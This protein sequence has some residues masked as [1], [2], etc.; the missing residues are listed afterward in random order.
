[1]NFEEDNTERRMSPEEDDSEGA[2]EHVHVSLNFD[3]I[4]DKKPRREGE[5]IEKSEDGEKFIIKLA[6]DRV[7]EV[8]AVAYYIWAMCDGDKTV[9]DIIQ[10]ISKE[11]QIEEDQIRAPIVAVLEQLQEAALI[12]I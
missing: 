8:A 7:Y 2:H 11:A 3:D 10:E 6:E 9:N 12:S 5:Y 4:K 1:M